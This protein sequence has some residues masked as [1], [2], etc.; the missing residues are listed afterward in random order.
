M[1]TLI[2][3]GVGA[4]YGAAFSMLRDCVKHADA[5]AW[6]AIVG[7]FPFWH[8]T[9]HTLYA[10]DLYLSPDEHSFS[11]QPFHLEDYNYLGQ[12]PWSPQKTSVADRPYHKDTLR[13]YL[14][15]CRAKAKL[16]METET[17]ATLAGPSGF[18]WLPFT[19]LELHLYNIRHMQHHGGQLCALLRRMP[20]KGVEWVGSQPL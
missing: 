17:E 15:T 2:R 1:I 20:G 7:Q 19:R 6:Q 16:T 9:Y 3:S 18:S 13:A 14:D 4:Q 12:Q 5:A 11:P 8:I 10:T